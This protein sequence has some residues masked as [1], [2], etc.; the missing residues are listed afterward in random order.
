MRESLT[1]LRILTGALALVAVLPGCQR[2]QGRPVWVEQ[3]E[4]SL[5]RI[6][7]AWDGLELTGPP[8][9]A[10]AGAE[11]LPFALWGCDWTRGS[12]GL[13]LTS[14]DVLT[15]AA[16]LWFRNTFHVESPGGARKSTP[17]PVPPLPARG[18]AAGAITPTELTSLG[19]HDALLFPAPRGFG[20][21]VP[22]RVLPRLRAGQEIV[23]IGLTTR[24][25]PELRRGVVLGAIGQHRETSLALEPSFYGAPVYDLNGQLAGVVVW[26]P[27]EPRLGAAQQAQ[28]M[29]GA[30]AIAPL[31]R[32]L[33][34]PPKTRGRFPVSRLSRSP[35][36]G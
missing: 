33:L 9:L 29:G 23:V 11:T 7:T 34:S 16:P 21:G 14:G 2:E 36:A 26:L 1:R 6:I 12:T 31:P 10:Q 8:S 24:G 4:G 27:S 22:P 35:S 30:W 13:L 32:Q 5:V 18:S 3:A 17:C 15:A 28:Q 19:A 25:R 20:P